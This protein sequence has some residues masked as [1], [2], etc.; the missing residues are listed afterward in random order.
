MENSISW[1]P[2]DG[3][4]VVA[5]VTNI[6]GPL[7][8]A[9]LVRLG[10]EVVKIEPLQGD[11]LQAAAPRWYAAL[12]D[13]MRV[14]RL[15]LRSARAEIASELSL[16]DI[17]LTSM[18]PRAFAAA[19]L[20]WAELHASYPRLCHIAIVG[21][22]GEHADRAGHDLTYQARAGLLAPPMMP[23]I[24]LAD[25]FAAQRV[26]QIVTAA[27]YDRERTGIGTRH[28]VAIADAAVRLGDS[29][30]YGLTS[31]GGA[32]SGTQATYRLYRCADGWVALAALEPHF[33]RRLAQVLGV[34][35]LDA[36]TLEL[37]FA[38]RSCAQW[39]EIA[40]RDDLPIAS[41]RELEEA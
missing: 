30:R 37:C 2:L 20:Q 6:P 39:E 13:G 40:Q 10:A 29:E 19:G 26:T 3:S 16:A 33:Q 7:A 21:E 11:A 23:R 25:L 9:D 12:V 28:E 41:V 35:A 14:L 1:R 31:G 15:D 32:L 22:S 27:L 34:G 8:A 4:R 18:R 5:I 38:E 24:A 17:L 36:Q